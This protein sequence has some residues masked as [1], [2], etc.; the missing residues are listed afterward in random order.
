MPIADT[1]GCIQVRMGGGWSVVSCGSQGGLVR[2]RPQREI[3][4]TPLNAGSAAGY[5]STNNYI[6]DV[7]H[8]TFT[9]LQHLQSNTVA[10]P[11]EQSHHLGC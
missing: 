10:L 2:L 4:R 5:D 9:K 7:K 11:H 1:C 3:V 6:T 8:A